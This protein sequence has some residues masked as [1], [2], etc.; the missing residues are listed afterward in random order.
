M[1]ELK[2][3]ITDIFTEADQDGTRL[4][5]EVIEAINHFE[6]EQMEGKLSEARESIE[7]MEAINANTNK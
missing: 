5:R 2:E 6:I 3:A 1:N 4:H 7:R